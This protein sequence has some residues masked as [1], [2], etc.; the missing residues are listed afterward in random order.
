LVEESQLVSGYLTNIHSYLSTFSN[1]ESTE[2]MQ[3]RIVTYWSDRAESIIT[4]RMR[5][6]KLSH[7]IETNLESIHCNTPKN[8]LSVNI[9]SSL[10]VDEKDLPTITLPSS[11]SIR[12]TKSF[13]WTDISYAHTVLTQGDAPPVWT[14]HLSLT[15]SGDTMLAVDAKMATR[16]P[17]RVEIC[18]ESNTLDKIV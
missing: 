12:Q 17:P 10:P 14:C 11:V 9:S 5:N 16:S 3:E 13:S 1:Y 15:W 6:N 4:T 7:S 18:I 2:W 8:A